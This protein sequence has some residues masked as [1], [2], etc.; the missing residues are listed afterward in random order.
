[1]KKRRIAVDCDDVIVPTAELIIN[2][3][4]YTYDAKVSLEH[5]YVKNPA[6]WNASDQA[7][8]NVRITDY[9][10]S[11]EFQQAQPFREAIQALRILKDK[12]D[13]HIVT[14]RSD[15]LTQATHD[16]LMEYLPEV[17]QS[18][19]FTN[20]FGENA[21][22]KSDVCQQLGA[23]LLID[24]HMHHAAVVADCGIEVLLFGTYPWNEG[25]IKHANIRRVAD[26][27]EILE[28]LG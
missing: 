15:F 12:H 27:D 6:L 2:H 9:L 5:L 26:W 21:R 13:L 23:D 25:P 1:M 11:E 18:V 28:L 14:G 4:N 19:E 17:F 24:D 8:V 16:M 22:S 3:Y 20:F 7:E 10:M